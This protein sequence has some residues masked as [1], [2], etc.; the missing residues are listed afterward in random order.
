MAK[1]GEKR[2]RRSVVLEPDAA[3][4]DIGAEEIY[5]AVPPD[6]DEESTRRFSSFTGDL[7]ALADW[8]GRCRIQSV[9]MESTGVYWIPLFQILEER[10]FKVYLVNA[11]YLKSVPGRKSDVSDCQWIQYLHSVGLL[12]ASFRP[13]EAICALRTLWRHRGSLLEMAA[14]H[15]LHMQK[16]LSQ[17]NLQLHHVLSDITGTSGQA[18]LDAILSGKRDPV[19]LA[20]LCHCRVKSPRDRVAQALVGAAR[21]SIHPEAVIGGIPLLPEADP[22]VGSRDSTFDAGAS[23]RDRAS[24]A[25]THQG[26]RISPAGQRSSVRSSQRALPHCRRRSHRHPRSQRSYC[27]SCTDRDRH[28]CQQVSQRFCFRLMARSLPG[29]TSQR[30]QGVVL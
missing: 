22:R 28:R 2:E 17:M 16:A 19:E 1:R 14:E 4:I 8:L 7:H 6:R 11:H 20:Q 24:H 21:T 9:A 3:G 18:I 12:R 29:K 27:A 5:V 23:Q 10:G 15:I 26:H 25:T 13:P 30:R